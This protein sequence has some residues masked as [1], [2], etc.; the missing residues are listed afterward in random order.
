[1]PNKLKSV[2]QWGHFFTKNDTG[3]QRKIS[4][5][6]YSKR[7]NKSIALAELRFIYAL[8]KRAS[9]VKTKC[10]S[11]ESSWTMVPVNGNKPQDVRVCNNQTLAKDRPVMRVELS[12]NANTWM[13]FSVSWFFIF[14]KI[15]FGLGRHLDGS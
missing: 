6:M 2:I 5:V 3:R 10:H 4:I 11:F 12:Q 14:D 1:M 13:L 8:I 15:I 7:Y 9:A